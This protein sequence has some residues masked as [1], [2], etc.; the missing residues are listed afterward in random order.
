VLLHQ[1][2]AHNTYAK[3]S[4][5]A[6]C[7][8]LQCVHPV[9]QDSPVVAQHAGSSIQVLMGGSSTVNKHTCPASSA[10][11]AARPAQR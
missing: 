1:Q 4:A 9:V 8:E 10:A 6:R 7:Q 11:A 5:Y 3:R 2:P